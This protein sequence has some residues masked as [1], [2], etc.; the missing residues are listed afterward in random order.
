MN[1]IN[2][3]KI[4]KFI[5]DPDWHIIEDCLNEYIEPLR[6]IDNINLDNEPAVVKA[7]IVVRKEHY[8]RINSFLIDIGLIKSAQTGGTSQHPFK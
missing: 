8:D 7:E 1:N 5:K 4:N 6:D 3:E 2:K